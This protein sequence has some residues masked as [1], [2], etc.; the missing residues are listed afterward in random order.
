MGGYHIAL[1]DK[2]GRLN[3]TLEST[4]EKGRYCPGCQRPNTI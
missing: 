4:G 3:V 2:M 1:K